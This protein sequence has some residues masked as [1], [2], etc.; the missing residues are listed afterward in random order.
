MGRGLGVV[1]YFVYFHLWQALPRYRAAYDAMAR[2]DTKRPKAHKLRMTTL[3]QVA[4]AHAAQT[5]IPEFGVEMET[6]GA[7]LS[8]RPPNKIEATFKLSKNNIVGDTEA[9]CADARALYD[10][11]QAKKSKKM[12]IR[13]RKWAARRAAPQ[14]RP[15]TKSNRPHNQTTTKKSLTRI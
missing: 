15:A 12:S 1:Q 9:A 3:E 14:S 10:V 5:G 11:W 7:K 4:K 2:E 13:I 6:H 8:F